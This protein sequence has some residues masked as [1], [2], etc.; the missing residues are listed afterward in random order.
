MCAGAS[1]NASLPT[2]SHDNSFVTQAAVTGVNSLLRVMSLSERCACDHAVCAQARPLT[3]P[4]RQRPASTTSSLTA[5]RQ[6]STKVSTPVRLTV[7]CCVRLIAATDCERCACD[8]A[9]CAQARPLTIPHRQRP[10][11]TTS[12]LTAFGRS[13]TKVSTPVRLV[14][15]T[16]DCC[17]RLIA[18]TDCCC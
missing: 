8:H 16:V 5:F 10:A 15:L 14:R 13:S 2:S 12:S 4:H 7:D 3:I 9:A 11:S 1:P 18:A 17:V 6:S